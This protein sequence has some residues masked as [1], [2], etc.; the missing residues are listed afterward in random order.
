MHTAL[1]M[2]VCTSVLLVSEPL[3][4]P[5]SEWPMIGP[6]PA[7]GILLRCASL[8]ASLPASQPASHPPSQ[9]AGQPASQPASQPA[10]Q[11]AGR[12]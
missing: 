6:A 2:R 3:P 7:R 4:R 9:P 11:P 5:L 12:V 10:G 8:P 1:L